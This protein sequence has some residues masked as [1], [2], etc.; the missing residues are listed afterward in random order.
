MDVDKLKEYVELDARK[1]RL[2][3]ELSDVKERLAKLESD[4]LTTFE[5]IGMQN[6][7]ID[8]TTVYV[9]RQLWANAKDGDRHRAVAALKRSG[10]TEM[11]TETFNTNTLSAYVRELDAVGEDLPPDLEDAISV[12]EKF[13]LRTRRG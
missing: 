5:E 10:L 13:S 7:R 4:L 3:D 11:V 1:R 9:H 8:G 6:T 2:N 12:S